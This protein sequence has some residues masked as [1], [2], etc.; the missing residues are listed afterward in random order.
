MFL[1]FQIKKLNKEIKS[2][3]NM[4]SE[5]FACL[6]D[7]TISK[8]SKKCEAY[9]T[10]TID[11]KQLNKKNNI[12]TRQKEFLYLQELCK[13]QLTFNQFEL[14]T[15]EKSLGEN[16]IVKST[17]NEEVKPVKESKKKEKK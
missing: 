6:D 16:I 1:L 4:L 10:Y 15:K 11:N 5:I 14:S 8:I 3:K 13:A 2:Y 17:L 7:N 9:T 12:V